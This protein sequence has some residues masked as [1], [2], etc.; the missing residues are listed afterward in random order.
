MTDYNPL[1]LC[2]KENRETRHSLVSF[3]K[4]NVAPLNGWEDIAYK[5]IYHCLNC[6]A[7]RIY[8]CTEDPPK[9]GE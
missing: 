6:G 3:E 7:P 1:I 8:G 5:H 4:A 2:S 9:I